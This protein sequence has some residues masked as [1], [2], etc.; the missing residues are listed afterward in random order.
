VSAASSTP[1]LAVEDVS[2]RYGGVQALRG[3]SLAVQRGEVLA[4]LGKN[5][6]GKSTLVKVLCGAVQPDAGAILLGGEP[7]RIGSPP[8][9]FRHGIV[10]VHQEP[11]VVPGLN[12]GDNI[13][14]GRWG[15]GVVDRDHVVKTSREAL[16]R[17]GSDL[18]PRQSTASLSIAEWQVIEIARALT[19]DVRVLIMDEPTSA[20]GPEDAAG[21]VSTVRGLAAEGV[22]VIYVSH[23][24]DEIPRVADQI[25]VLREGEVVKTLPTQG[26][27]SRTVIELMVGREWV[28]AETSD[29]VEPVADAD[30]A[31]ALSVRDMRVA[32]RVYGVDLDIRRGEVV[33]LAGLVG[34]GRTELMRAIYGTVECEGEVRVGGRP[35]SRR[36]PERMRRAGV[37]LLT[38]DRKREG[39]FPDLSVA[40]NISLGNLGRVS[41][42]GWI[43]P[44]RRADAAH[45]AIDSLG[46]KVAD[47]EQDV[48]GLS[49]G[50]QQKVVI[51]RCLAAGSNVLLLDEPTRG[52][53]VEAK[54][55]IYEFL[56]SLAERDLAVVVAPSEFDELTHLC[57]RVVVLRE[58]RVAREIRGPRLDVGEIMAAAMGGSEETQRKS[59][60]GGDAPAGSAEREVTPR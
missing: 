29:V 53:D 31:T 6:A 4:L 38:D 54:F 18:D 34:A 19:Q 30:G 37:S 48:S 26:T 10:T 3:V 52:V 40:D 46:I 16:R 9:A 28:E 20:L 22:A 44:R 59:G 24:L 15:R 23:R 1:V 12:V 2:K 25:T 56:R 43:A 32:G 50:N 17:L 55:Q 39:L 33:G 58:G 7:V 5:G 51:A 49:G 8:E 21:L 60:G 47:S 45:A 11:H 41:R 27:S 35:M 42:F 13:M 57:D 36:G 14:L